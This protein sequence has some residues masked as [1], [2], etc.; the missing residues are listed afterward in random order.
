MVK[1]EERESHTHA[2]KSLFVSHLLIPHWPKRVTWCSL[3]TVGWPCK[4][5]WHKYIDTESDK[6]MKPLMKSNHNKLI[7]LVAIG[8]VTTPT[9]V[10]MIY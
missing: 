5:T 9:D 2:F 8:Y 4:V 6:A 1:T 3:E 10:T 7:N